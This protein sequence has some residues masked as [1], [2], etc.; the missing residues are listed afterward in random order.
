MGATEG[1]EGRPAIYIYHMR[2]C[3]PKKCTAQK[4]GKMGLARVVHRLQAV[5]AGSLMLYPSSETMVSPEDRARI[6]Q[7]GVA[8]VDCSWNRLR[9]IHGTERFAVRKLPFLLAGNP[10]NY[11]IPQKL[12]TV[13]AIAATLLIAGFD[14]TA[15]ELLSKFKWGVTFLSLNQ[16]P[17]SLYSAAR[18]NHEVRRISEDYSRAYFPQNH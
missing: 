11:A 7:R 12:S 18:D 5:P 17:L 13:E 4:L 16:E 14:G 1:E 10:V 3:D 9:R 2:E 8:A 15:R 6:G